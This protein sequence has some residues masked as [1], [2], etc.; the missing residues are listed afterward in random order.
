M[1]EKRLFQ[2]YKQLLK[3]PASVNNPQIVDLR[4]VDVENSIFKWQAVIV[5]RTKADSPYYYNG[6]WTL[7]IDV[8]AQ[9]PRKPAKITFSPATRILH[10]NI[11]LETGEICLDI[12]TDDAW[13]PAWNLVHLVGAIL[14]LLDEPEPDSPLNVDSANL[15]RSDKLAF[16]SAVQHTMWKHNT[17]IETAKTTSGVKNSMGEDNYRKSEQNDKHI[18]EEKQPT[19][20]KNPSKEGKDTRKTDTETI[21]D[22]KETGND[23]EIEQIQDG[24]HVLNLSHDGCTISDQKN[25][26]ISQDSERPNPEIE[27]QDFEFIH[28]IGRHITQ[29]FLKKAT[30]VQIASPPNQQHVSSSHQLAAV[31]Q[32]VSNNVAKQ[33]EQI[34]SRGASRIHSPTVDTFD[35]K[36]DIMSAKES[37]L[38][39]IDQQ[40]DEIR[41]LQE[42]KSLV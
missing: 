34:C 38:E 20:E 8:D 1:A 19:E 10:P 6:Q 15:Y 21:T 16:E 39:K 7:D 17:L 32:H 14:I 5:K 9:Y 13:S 12:L 36:A 40:V 24:V 18:A 4:P 25:T 28:D 26:G 29:Q 41:R 33:I 3:T 23:K 37:F 35:K 11:R 2:E 30:E 31:H 42:K 22:K 27:E